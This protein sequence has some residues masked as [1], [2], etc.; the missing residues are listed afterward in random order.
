M[1]RMERNLYYIVF[2][3]ENVFVASCLDVEVTTDGATE[4]A[5]VDNLREALEIYFDSAVI[6]TGRQISLTPHRHPTK[7]AMATHARNER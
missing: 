4:Q 1:S 3:E 6:G 2:P 7:P 5:A